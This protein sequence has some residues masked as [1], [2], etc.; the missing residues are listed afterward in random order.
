VLS[1]IEFFGGRN[2]PEGAVDLEVAANFL[3]IESR[4][5]GTHLWGGRTT[6]RLRRL[7]E[8]PGDKLLL[9]YK[10]VVLVDN[11]KPLPTLGFLI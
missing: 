9:A 5:R 6:Y 2:N 7:G 11:D 1:N 3:V 4:S 8:G 10:K